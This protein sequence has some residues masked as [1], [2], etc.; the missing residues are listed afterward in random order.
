MLEEAG[1]ARD[2]LR[3]SLPNLLA[4]DQGRRRHRRRHRRRLAT[5]ATVKALSGL[6]GRSAAVV[7]FPIR[8]SHRAGRR[9]GAKSRGEPLSRSSRQ[10]DVRRTAVSPDDTHQPRSLGAARSSPAIR[11][12]SPDWKNCTRTNDSFEPSPIR[13][14]RSAGWPRPMATSS[15]IT[16]SGTIIPGPRPNDMEG[17]GWQSVHDP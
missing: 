4:G 16:S 9:A 11:R 17:W 2:D 12:A 15:G 10:C 14:R 5:P 8:A 13:S 3:L 1:I 7:G 6:A